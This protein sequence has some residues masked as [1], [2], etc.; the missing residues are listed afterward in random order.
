MLLEDQ[1]KDRQGQATSFG[2]WYWVLEVV[3]ERG[4][5]YSREI[6][7]NGIEIILFLFFQ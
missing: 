1:Q 3:V 7:T 4:R 6:L 2:G 5:G